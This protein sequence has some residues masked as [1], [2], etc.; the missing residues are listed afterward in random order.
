VS[1]LLASTSPRRAD[2]L[3]AAG[4]AFEQ[5]DPGVD[6]AQEGALASD[7]SARGLSAA[8]VVRRLALAKLL[9]ALRSA[10]RGRPVLAADTLVVDGEQLL[11]K[12]SS[13]EH[14]RVVLQALRGRSHL[15]LTGVAL[16]LPDG[17]LRLGV[18]ESRVQMREFGPQAL[19]DYLACGLWAGKAAGYGVQDP[20]SASLVEGVDGSDSNVRGLPVEW[21]TEALSAA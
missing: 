19:E 6:D 10:G 20:E 18:V 4:V 1:L 12:P 3:R 13:L 17:R 16:A 14:C 8:H 15:V 21:V 2:L 9:A 5:V 7:A 11:G